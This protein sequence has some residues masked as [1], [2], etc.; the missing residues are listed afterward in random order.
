MDSRRKKHGPEGRS[1]LALAG[2]AL[3][4]IITK[5]D[6]TMIQ[7]EMGMLY[8]LGTATA[9]GRTTAVLVLGGIVGTAVAA[10]AGRGFDFTLRLRSKEAKVSEVLGWERSKATNH[11]VDVWKLKLKS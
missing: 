2:L 6:Q 11:V 7:R 4:A 10:F 5:H 3:A 1:A 8:L 9:R